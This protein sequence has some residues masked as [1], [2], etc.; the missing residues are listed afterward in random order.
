MDGTASYIGSINLSWTSL[1]KNREIG[2]VMT[3]P[4]NVATVMS[5]FEKDWTTANAF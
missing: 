2:L 5:T 3:E 1:T 4:Q